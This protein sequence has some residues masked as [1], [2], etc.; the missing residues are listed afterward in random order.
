MDALAD[1]KAAVLE[2]LTIGLT[3]GRGAVGLPDSIPV[4][5]DGYPV[6]LDGLDGAIVETSTAGGSAWQTVRLLVRF[7]LGRTSELSSQTLADRYRTPT[8]PTSVK[9][10]IESDRTLGGLARYVMVGPPG[11]LEA[12]QVGQI[13][14]LI[15]DWPVEVLA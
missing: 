1:I 6:V 15:V 13:D 2:P 12:A 14:Y 8:G 4:G 3:D 7:Y 10:L 9:A 5:A 11:A